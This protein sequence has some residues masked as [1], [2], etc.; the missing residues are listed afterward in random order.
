M[1]NSQARGTGKTSHARREE[2]ENESRYESQ[3][4]G[5]TQRMGRKSKKPRGKM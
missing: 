2:V 3:G 1:A 5:H 4:M